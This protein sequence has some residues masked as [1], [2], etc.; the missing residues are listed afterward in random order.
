[1]STDGIYET[2]DD[3]VF[4][5]TGD[6][7]APRDVVRVRV[8]P[9]VTSI[10]GYVFQCR[11]KLA[12]VELCEGLVEIGERTF[13]WCDQ[14]ITKI[15]IPNSLR[16][17]NDDC[18]FAHSLRTPIRLNDGIE[19]IGGEAFGNCIFTN[20][21]VPPLITVIPWRLLIDCRSLFSLELPKNVTEIGYHALFNC[22]CL[23][24]VAFPSN[25]V[26]ND[27]VLFDDE[28]HQRTDLYQLFDSMAEI[29]S[30]MQHR[31]DGLPI[32]V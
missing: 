13:Q 31:F 20:F 17:I 26:F 24:N 16:R 12:E 27:T 15:N 4:I 14:S 29:I 19:S 2:Y 25:A 1:M 7:R 11:T 28:Y 6:V 22:Y 9:S 5:F 23:R 32:H 30:E 8:D 10:P 3:Q 21:R 18:A